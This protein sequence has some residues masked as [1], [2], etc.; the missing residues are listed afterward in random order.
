MSAANRDLTPRGGNSFKRS[1]ATGPRSG[2]VVFLHVPMFGGW[3]AHV[4]VGMFWMKR[5]HAHANI[6][7]SKHGRTL[8]SAP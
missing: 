5:N 8:N 6:G 1:C 3:H 7:R 4:R 2:P